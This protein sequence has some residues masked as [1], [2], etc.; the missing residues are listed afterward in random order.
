V[1]YLL[2]RD[3]VPHGCVMAMIL[4]VMIMTIDFGIIFLEGV[5]LD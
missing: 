5:P 2:F 3:S 1:E 4:M